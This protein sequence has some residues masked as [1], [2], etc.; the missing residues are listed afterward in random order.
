[1][2]GIDKTFVTK[3]EYTEVRSFWIK[4][5][6][7]QKKELGCPIGL[8]PFCMFTPIK[9]HKITPKFLLK[10]DNDLRDFD[11]DSTA[12]VLWNTNVR[13]DQWLAKNCQLPFIQTRLV[14]QYGSIEKLEQIQTTF[15]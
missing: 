5:Y 1:M 11:D 12:L 3:K 13:Q 7:Q 4:T 2:A 8:Y 10:N 6:K 9:F 14:E 15:I